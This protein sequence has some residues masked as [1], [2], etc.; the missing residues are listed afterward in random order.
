MMQLAVPAP[1]EMLPWLAQR[2]SL[3]LSPTLEAIAAVDDKGQ[4]AG[5]VGFD[6][7]TPNAVY[8]H[9]AIE[10]PIAL[11]RLVWRAFDLA[12]NRIGRG[13]IFAPVMS[14]NRK[15]IDL[16]V[17]LG[18]EQVA[19]LRDAWEPHV[20]MLLFEMRKR[21]CRWIS[22]KEAMRWAA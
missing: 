21:D 7:W 17:H 20:D 15:S 1:R 18:F 12:F 4:I 9:I 22:G 19:R 16:V 11:R 14:T 2:A 5:M 13:V 8:V 6:G 3:V 10:K